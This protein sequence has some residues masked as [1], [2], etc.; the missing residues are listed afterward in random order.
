M[1]QTIQ[2][3]ACEKD[4]SLFILLLSSSSTIFTFCLISQQRLL[5]RNHKYEGRHWDSRVY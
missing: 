5:L 2:L 4:F 3:E 1:H